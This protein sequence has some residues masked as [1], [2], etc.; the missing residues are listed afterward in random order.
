MVHRDIIVS[1]PPVTVHPVIFGYEESR[2]FH[3]VGPKVRTHWLLHYVTKGRGFFSIGGKTHE[4]EAGCLF[5]IPPYTQISYWGDEEDLWDYIWV[6]FHLAGQ[7]PAALKQPVIR[8][9]DAGEVFEKMKTCKGRF[10]PLSACILELFEVLG[11]GSADLDYV[12]R[13]LS[14]IHAEYDH[15]LTVEQL[16]KRLGLDRSYFSDLFRE[17]T[18]ETP[19]QYLIRLRMNKA[20]ELMAQHGYTPTLAAQSCG[21]PDLAQF[22][23]RFKAQFGISPRQYRGQEK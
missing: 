11:A 12:T 19:G 8:C 2:P 21:Y 7:A 17:R 6:G 5:V 20:A 22:S 18:G 23:K 10:L 4:V 13:A 3:R 15:D 9:P 14:C 1:P 16:A